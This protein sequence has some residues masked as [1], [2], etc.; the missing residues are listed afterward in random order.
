LKLTEKYGQSCGCRTNSTA[1][2]TICDKDSAC[3]PLPALLG[4]GYQPLESDMTKARAAAERSFKTAIK[5]AIGM[6]LISSL[7]EFMGK[8]DKSQTNI[9]AS[10][11][12]V[13]TRRYGQGWSR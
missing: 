12:R 10:V 5:T 4:F 13:N 6:G 9:L 3:I 7:E 8:S 11:S 2:V 1:T